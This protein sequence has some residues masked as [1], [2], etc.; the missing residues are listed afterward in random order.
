MR[1]LSLILI[2]TITIFVLNALTTDQV[3]V[4]F[5]PS[6][7]FVNS[8]ST[9]SFDPINTQNQPYLTTLTI[10]N[11]SSVKYLIQMKMKAK[12]NQTQLLN[13]NSGIIFTASDSI[14]PNEMYIMTNRDFIAQSAGQYFNAPVPKISVQDVIDA[15]PT[16][17]NAMMSGFFPDGTITFSVWVR[18]NNETSW[19]NQPSSECKVQIKNTGNIS[20]IYPGKIIG[21]HPVE[22]V[23]VRPVAF[24][25]N[26]NKPENNKFLLTVK[27]YSPN[28]MPTLNSV[29]NTGTYLL[30]NQEVNSNMYNEFI[31]LQHNHFYAW[32]VSIPTY[33]ITDPLVVEPSGGT[34][35]GQTIIKSNWYV[36]RFMSNQGVNNSNELRV[37]LNNMNRQSIQA[38]LNQGYSPTG[39]IYYQGQWYSDSAAIDLLSS[40]IGH[41]FDVE[42]T[43]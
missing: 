26:C 1:R 24:L 31:P 11:K 15:S 10:K 32:Q 42:I 37:L 30:N 22:Q 36:F 35:S 33:Q 7:L 3:E 18:R 28:I 39:M 29:E 2:L 17:K 41:Q 27:E 12:W 34:N 20:L 23:N 19:A 8:F 40:F 14:A 6:S 16:L 4:K 21:S 9:A 5:S 13:G 25:W 43:N 38:L